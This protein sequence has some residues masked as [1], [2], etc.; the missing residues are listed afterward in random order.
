ML[1]PVAV[2]F[3]AD[4]Q[5]G[6]SVPC[7]V[8]VSLES[9]LA[10][11]VRVSVDAGQS[12]A[13]RSAAAVDLALNARE[14]KTVPV[15]LIPQAV[16]ALPVH[17]TIAPAPDSGEKWWLRYCLVLDTSARVVRSDQPGLLTGRAAELA[18]LPEEKPAADQGRAK[19]TGVT[20]GK[21]WLPG[22]ALEAA[23]DPEVHF[24][25][26]EGQAP[27]TPG[28]GLTWQRVERYEI[29]IEPDELPAVEA[30]LGGSTSAR[31][32]EGG[33]YDVSAGGLEKLQLQGVEA[34]VVGGTYHYVLVRTEP[35]RGSN[36][37]APE[38]DGSGTAA[39]SRD[40]SAVGRASAPALP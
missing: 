35:V 26:P 40:G 37:A 10:R 7:T 11:N 14:R 31:A 6:V 33:R 2:G 16:G 32:L 20:A 21:P 28:R 9:V 12:V 3:A 17:V 5:P 4:D 25:S 30:L 22:D 38:L 39:V 34:E 24:V 29:L 18:P 19:Q 1:P 23:L 8:D 15:R 27:G 13:L 36:E